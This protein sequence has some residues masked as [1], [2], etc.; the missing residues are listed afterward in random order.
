MILDD[1]QSTDKKF[2]MELLSKYEIVSFFDEKCFEL[3]VTFATV[4]QSYME[5][6]NPLIAMLY[7]V[8]SYAED[9][10][11]AERALMCTHLLINVI[12]KDQQLGIMKELMPLM[13]DV[14]FDSDF[15]TKLMGKVKSMK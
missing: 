4:L 5:K 10:T 13:M 15:F 1:M 8:R 11:D 14:G 9:S 6:H 7:A 3:S 2:I 12:P